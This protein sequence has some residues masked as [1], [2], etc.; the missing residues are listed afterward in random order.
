VS[1]LPVD[2]ARLRQQFP[3]LTDED[4]DAFETVTR[5]ILEQK[6]PVERGRVTRTIMETGRAARAKNARG[7]AL[8]G[9]ERLALTYLGAV[10]K[11]QGRA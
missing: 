7:D 3:E 10:G 8:N 4:I 9:E 2:P 5:R 6:G 11:M 1:G